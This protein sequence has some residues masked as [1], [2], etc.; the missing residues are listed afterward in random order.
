ML[1]SQKMNDRLNDQIN[2]E[3][4]SSY[5]YL[6]M[7]ASLEKMN[8]KVFA[9]YYFKHADEER[10][11]AMKMFKYIVDASGTVA[12]KA[13]DDPKGKWDSVEKIVQQSLDHELK[14]TG[15]INDLVA[16]AEQEKD[17]AT[18]SFLQWYVDEQ[19]EEVSSA[20]HLLALVKM[21]GPGQLL[22]LEYR[23]SQMLG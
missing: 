5:I 13:I 15:R 20:E 17:Y 6:A 21:A 22:N 4:Y 10:M 8:L 7:A 18:R 3:L 23:V 14:V 19:V 9:Q 12:L 2:Y 11:H 1:I 16:L